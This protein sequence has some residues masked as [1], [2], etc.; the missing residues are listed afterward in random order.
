MNL[1]VV[2]AVAGEP[3]ELVH[4]AELHPGRGDEREH[5]LQPVTIRRPRGLPASTNS[6]TIRAPSSSAFRALASRWA[7]IEKPSSVPPRSACSAWRRAGR[8]RPAAPACR[9]SVVG[10]LECAGEGG[11]G[12]G[13]AVLLRWGDRVRVLYSA[14]LRLTSGSDSVRSRKVVGVGLAGA[15]GVVAGLGDVQH[16]LHQLR[17]CPVPRGGS[18]RRRSCPGSLPEPAPSAPLP[19]AARD[20]RSRVGAGVRALTSISRYGRYASITVTQIMA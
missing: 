7:G 14:S 11:S 2:G 10:E 8:T 12:G 6:R 4:D 15:V 13:H 16:P 1:H 9:P 20:G 17:A 18:C 3:V 5:V 19:C